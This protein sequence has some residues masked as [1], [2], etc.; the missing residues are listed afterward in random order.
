[1]KF[2]TSKQDQTEITAYFSKIPKFL[3]S[4]GLYQVLLKYKSD[5][6]IS[7]VEKSSSKNFK[8]SDNGQWWAKSYEN[9]E[10]R[11]KNKFEKYVEFFSHEEIEKLIIITIYLLLFLFNLYVPFIKLG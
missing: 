6:Y 11:K 7:K 3:K 2:R 1:M 10:Y 4:P 8:K 9:A 5:H